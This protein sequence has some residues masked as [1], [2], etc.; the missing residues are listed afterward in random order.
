M[1]VTAGEVIQAARDLHPSFDKNQH[2]ELTLLRQ[3]SLNQQVLIGKA[4]QRYPDLFSEKQ[5]IGLPVADFD[6]GTPVDNPL[7]LQD[8]D[9]LSISGRP[10][11]VTIIPAE[12]RNGQRPLY[13]VF[14]RNRI[15]YQCGALA[16]WT[17][18]VQLTLNFSKTV[19]NLTAL[20]DTMTLPPESTLCLAAMLGQL[21]AM[22]G[23]QRDDVPTAS[24]DRFTTAA[25]VAEDDFLRGLWLQRSAGS[26]VRQ[27][28]V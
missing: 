22:R 28:V 15:L 9:G 20:A 18:L 8:V 19:P 21:M 27:E 26:S 10:C 23:S 3:L 1:P 25:A 14:L 11:E 13:S 24:Q 5:V 17:G 7:L 6:A 2:P 16:D 4:L 12:H